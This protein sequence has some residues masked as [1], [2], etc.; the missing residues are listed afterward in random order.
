MNR[1]I[2]YQIKKNIFRFVIPCFEVDSD[3]NALFAE[4]IENLAVG[5]NI[6]VDGYRL[7]DATKLV[8]ES[9]IIAQA[10]SLPFG[11]TP[12]GHSMILWLK[13]AKINVGV[14]NIEDVA[15]GLSFYFFKPSVKWEDFLVS[16]SCKVAELFKQGLLTSYLA[17]IDHGSICMFGGSMECE[18]TVSKF[19][20]GL[21]TH[22]Y[23]EDNAKGKHQ[24]L[25]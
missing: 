6:F 20:K 24:R 21:K 11:R 8:D 1:K 12:Y 14:E 10:S 15:V 25:F 23:V 13:G 9:N 3:M 5:Q 19:I 2:K 22:G 4:F 16:R 7:F 17:I 18:D